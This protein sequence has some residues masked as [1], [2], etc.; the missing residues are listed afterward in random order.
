MKF[1][2]G[3]KVVKTLRKY[4]NGKPTN[5]T[6]NNVSGQPDYIEKYLSDDCPV[7]PLP[8]GVNQSITNAAAPTMPNPT[9]TFASDNTL[10][11]NNMIGGWTTF[12]SWTPES[13]VNM[14]GDFYS[15]NNGQLYKHHKPGS[16]R[17]IFYGTPYNTEVEFVVNEDPSSVKMFR[18]IKTEGSSNN[19]N[20]N[21]TTDTESGFI[22]KESF[23]KKEEMYY[24]YIRN[25]NTSINFKKLSVQGLGVCDS[26]NSGAN[27]ITIINL[28]NESLS[29]GDKILKS[30]ISNNVMSNVVEVG[31]VAS[32]LGE[33]ITCSSFGSAP[34]TGDFIFSA[35]NQTAESEGVRGYHAKVR[36]TND[37]TQA[38]ELFAVDA[39]VTKSNL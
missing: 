22:N 30:S 34:S 39:E 4:I 6:K 10:S 25:N 13:M 19:W 5:I 36:M 17:N 32:V 7:N 27:S 37:S 14:N 3:Y 16:E 24:A 20:I 11:Y 29:V 38:V 31:V 2:S 12:H 8:S 23:Q 21:V 1:R 15:F 18:S 9:K 35:K 28:N 33:T 26:V